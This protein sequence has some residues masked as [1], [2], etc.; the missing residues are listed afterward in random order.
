MTPHE[1]AQRAFEFIDGLDALTT[2]EAV[3]DRMHHVD[4]RLRF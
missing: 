4:L 1:H 2:T 3:V